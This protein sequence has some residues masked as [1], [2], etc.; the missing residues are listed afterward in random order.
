MRATNENPPTGQLTGLVGGPRPAFISPPIDRP[1]SY[2][3]GERQ[4]GRLVSF[5]T[6]PRRAASP[7][8][9][10]P[11]RSPTT[12]SEREV[13]LWAVPLAP[14]SP[15]SSTPQPPPPP[16]PP[17]YP[18]PP[19]SSQ[20]QSFVQSHNRAPQPPARLPLQKTA[21]SM[22]CSRARLLG[23]PAS[24]AVLILF[25]FQGAW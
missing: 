16:P 20:H 25:F 12:R 6:R 4:R 15:S 14:T 8:H 9:G 22:A 23:S 21:A 18:A 24:I 3:A 19:P 11:P 5:P 1:G 2:K 7:T 17:Y 13:G 10:T